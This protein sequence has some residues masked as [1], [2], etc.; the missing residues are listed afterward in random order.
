V[1]P[2]LAQAIEYAQEVLADT[3]RLKH[4]LLMQAAARRFLEDLE[5]ARG[6]DP[7]FLFD[8][9]IA[10]KHCKFIELLPHVEGRWTTKTIKLV[11]AQIFFVVQ[12]FGFRNFED[13]RRFTSALYAVA[14]KNAKSTLAAAILLS[15]QCLEEEPGAQV[16]TAATTGS[17]ARIVFDIAKKMVEQTPMLQSAFGLTARANAIH[18]DRK[19]RGSK[20]K[21]INAKASTQDGLNPAYVNLDE[22]HAHKTHDLLNVLMSAAGARSNPLFLYTTTE[23][24]EGSGP[25]PE[26]RLFAEQVLGKV[27]EADHYLAIFFRLDPED[28]EF[29]E[30]K[31]RKANPLM[32]FNPVLLQ[33]TQRLAIEAKA[34]PGNLAEFKVKR[35]NLSAASAAGIIDLLKWKGL[36]TFDA[37]YESLA[38]L[39]KFKCWGAFDL[40]STEDMCAWRLLW[41]LEDGRYATWGRYWVP[42]TQ[43]KR[44]NERKTVPYSGWIL[45][46]HVKETEGNVTDYQVVKADILEDCERFH[47]ETIAYD[48]WNATQFAGDLTDQGQTLKQ[49]IQGPRSYNPAFQLFQVCYLDGLLIHEG[50]PVLTWNM[51]NLVPRYDV[52]KNFAP[53]KSRSKEK[54]DGA[55]S[56]L[57]CFGLAQMEA[58][59]YV[60]MPKKGAAA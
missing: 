41:D 11:P 42:Q 7:P 51:A 4:G 12:L 33:A 45:S 52:N 18:C 49:F 22:I 39:E 48:A 43:V 36:P 14:R 47:P 29:D 38:W 26:Q 46:G 56:L 2:Y 54:I 37:S 28:D 23:G 6:V 34:M 16:I 60:T 9:A 15:C 31:W 19:G 27:I 55:V 44:R 32:E 50:N 8:E 35:L 25:W 20:F 59:G 58:E 24:Y 5:R 10:D 1:S 40:A 21:P 3:Q 30:L 57:M 17:Q 53:D 13:G